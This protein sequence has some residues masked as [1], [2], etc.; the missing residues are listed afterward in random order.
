MIIK[1][2][3]KGKLFFPSLFFLFISLF[4]GSTF[5]QERLNDRQFVALCSI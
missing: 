3:I 5:V 2:R 4:F 1:N